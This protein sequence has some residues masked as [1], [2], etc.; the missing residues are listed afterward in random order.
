MRDRTNHT[1]ATKTSIPFKTSK[2]SEFRRPCPSNGGKRPL[3]WPAA[4]RWPPPSCSMGVG[5][6]CGR[7]PEDEAL[8]LGRAGLSVEGTVLAG[9]VALGFDST[10]QMRDYAWLWG[11][12]G[13]ALGGDW[14]R[15]CAEERRPRSLTPAVNGTSP[16]W[17]AR[18][19][20]PRAADPRGKRWT[21]IKRDFFS[22]SIHSGFLGTRL[23]SKNVQFWFSRFCDNLY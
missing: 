13:G 20:N 4:S 10:I 18:W 22:E 9:P 3:L 2:P 17:V 19:Q 1:S 15:G 11:G 7:P 5:G 6:P 16:A 14:A 23:F 12:G 8:P 21:E